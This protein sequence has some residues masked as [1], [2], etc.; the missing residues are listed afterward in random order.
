MQFS[1]LGPLRVKNN[2]VPLNIGGNKQQVLLAA[3]ILARTKVVSTDRLVDLIW[4]T[5]PPNKPYGAIRS[6]V[7]HLR[8]VLEPD[9]SAGDR[10]RLLITRSPGYA[11]HIDP[12][13]VDA[14]QFEAAV[15]RAGALMAAGRHDQAL[16]VIDPALGLWESTDLSDSP[17]T[18]FAGEAERFLELRLRG[19]GLCLDAKLAAGRHGEVVADLLPLVDAEPAKEQYLSRLMLALHRGGRSAEAVQ[20]Y[21]RGYRAA[22]E[23]TGLE[24]SPA[25]AELERRILAAD[26]DL[27][28]NGSGPTGTV[29]A[30]SNGSGHNG[31]IG[32]AEELATITG[33]LQ[34]PGGRLVALTGEPGIGK[35]ELLRFAAKTAEGSG[36]RVAWGFGHRDS[37]TTPLAP[38][39]A[40]LTAIAETVEEQTLIRCVEQR[41]PELAMLSPTI[42]GRLHIE[43]EDARDATAL[44]EAVS[45]FLRRAAAD[46]PLLVCLDD[47]H[48]TDDS[49]LAMLSYLVP[50]LADQPVTFVTSWRDTEP[51]E[52]QQALA[53][54]DIGRLAE[55]H[56]IELGGLSTD[57]VGTL[58]SQAGGLAPDERPDE[59]QVAELQARTAGNPLFVK[60]LI[61]SGGSRT[62][63]KPNATINDVIAARLASVPEAS[64]QL[65]NIA[66]LCPAGF[67]ERLLADITGFGGD[68]LL[69]HL[70]LL[71]AARLIE[72]DP[73]RGDSFTFTHSLIGESLASQMSG[74]RKAR[75]HTQIAE[76]LDR[77]HTSIDQLAHHLLQ[78]AASG[79]P[80][81]AAT[82]A[83]RAAAEASRLHDHNSA[84][85]LIERGLAALKRSDDDQLRATLM[86]E[87]AQERKYKEHYTQSHAAAQEGFRLAKRAGDIDLMVGAALAFC[88]QGKD[89]DRFGI[90][91]LGY[92]NPPGPG[93][94]ML[95]QCLEKLEDGPLRVVV[96]ITYASQLFGEYDNPNEAAIIIGEAIAEARKSPHIELLVAA[97][98]QQL[99]ALQRHLPYELRKEIIDETIELADSLGTPSRIVATN[100]TLTVLRLEEGDMPGARR[101]VEVCQ[102]ALPDREEPAL[103]LFVES[104]TIALDLYEGR[105]AKAGEQI[106]QAMLRFERMGSAALDLLGIQYAVLL[107]ERGELAEVENLMRWKVSGYPGPAYGVALAMVLAEQGKTKATL[108]ALDEFGGDG[109]E[110]GGEG[111]LQFMT[112]SFYAETIMTLGDV[113][114]AR[115]LYPALAGAA[116]RTVTMYN[117]I[118]LFGSGSLY[119]GRLATLLGRYDE[120]TDHLHKAL[121]HHRAVGS[122]PYE[123]RTMLAMID[124]A[125]AAVLD[126]DEAGNQVQDL[127]GSARRLGAQLGMDWLTTKRL[128]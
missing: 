42:A 50:N 18:M 81:L 97:L 26:P 112:T 68:D 96:L 86:I 128:G 127:I 61:R 47:L 48:W 107:R 35:T 101:T 4:S 30:V 99:F 85:D 91:W 15:D 124:L 118:A 14:F 24:L 69:T 72:E 1:L 121:A 78:G 16:T 63:L 46:M 65:L 7:S 6:Y 125:E 73:V 79:D 55:G 3:L 98:S 10:N 92:W 89:E 27:Y 41:G 19:V 60:E 53:L 110:N 113:E 49:S 76:A 11:L 74:V 29:G 17:L 84:I 71:I 22:I 37:R 80:V 109:I 28:L 126:T 111:V 32:R 67:D 54:S 12:D 102:A 100:R 51:L 94:D 116:E 58:W 117:G 9:S 70:E 64:R 2:N 31:P 59:R 38:W 93:L 43:P 62:E 36:H 105:F 87:L 106:E 13:V 25:L 57:A 33:A 115:R 23:A 56:R 95:E 66:S 82:S 34:E 39:R 104:M 40:I 8:R 75:L 20:V 120:A 90:T 45:W 44:Q 88:G 108:E 5:N 123:L 83:L 52:E 21:Q 103:S 77:D 119:L 114:R 122:K